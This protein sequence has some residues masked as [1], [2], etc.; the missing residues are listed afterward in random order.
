MP[1]G[2]GPMTRAMLLTNVVEAAARAAGRRRPC[3]AMAPAGPGRRCGSVRPRRQP[4]RRLLLRQGGASCLGGVV[5]AP[6]GRGHAA[7]AGCLVVGASRSSLGAAC[8]GW[9]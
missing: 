1:G 5:A 2:V 4:W 3:A 9:R 7:R 8:C 6:P